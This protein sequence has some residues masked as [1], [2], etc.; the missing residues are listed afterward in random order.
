MNINDAI[1]A[2]LTATDSGLTLSRACPED[3]LRT[4]LTE[5]GSCLAEYELDG[6]SFASVS[7]DEL[8]VTV[9]YWSGK[10]DDSASAKRRA[11]ATYAVAEIASIVET[12]LH[13]GVSVGT[14]N[15]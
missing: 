12:L 13:I 3:H 6:R 9:S 14:G 1:I 4:R 8:E 15:V 11:A 5:R 2:A 7:I 10:A